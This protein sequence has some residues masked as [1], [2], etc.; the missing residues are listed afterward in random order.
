[1]KK[2]L[3]LLVIFSFLN[4]SFGTELKPPQACQMQWPVADSNEKDITSRFGETRKDGKTHK[5]L[6]IDLEIGDPVVAALVNKFINSKTIEVE[7]L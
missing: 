7:R 1:M 2:L 3:V 4:Y 5:G 6:D